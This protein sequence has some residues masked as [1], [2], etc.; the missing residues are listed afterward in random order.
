MAQDRALQ[1]EDERRLEQYEVVKGAARDQVQARVRQQAAQLNAAEQSEAAA[2]GNE[3]KREAIAEVLDT[4]VEVRRASAAA[5]ISQII[6]YVFYL[7]YGLIS[8]EV[9]FDLLGARRTNAFRNLIDVLS[10]P[11]L[12]PFKN[13]FPDP[14]SG[15]FQ[16]R[17]SYIAALVIYLLLHLAINGLLRMIAHRK[18]Q[19]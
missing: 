8:L 2:L 5:R 9:M 3:F 4:E 14:A 6:D 17:F 13:L 11:F 12:V 16:I 19:V 18:T 1:F 10:S 15:R 7:I